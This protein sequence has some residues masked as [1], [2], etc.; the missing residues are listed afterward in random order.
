MTTLSLETLKQDI[1]SIEKRINKLEEHID[2]K[3]T[4]INDQFNH[5]DVRFDHMERL[6]SS[7]QS[8]FD[9]R[10]G[11]FESRLNI[12][13]K[14]AQKAFALEGHSWAAT[15]SIATA[16]RCSALLPAWIAQSVRA[17]NSTETRALI[18]D[19]SLDRNTQ[20]VPNQILN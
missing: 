16:I 20:R 12:A 8:H 19:A 4:H 17:S 5:F 13:E 7:W 3:F 15:V 14:G 9:S 1:Q 6:L 2:E 18:D 10:V 11:H